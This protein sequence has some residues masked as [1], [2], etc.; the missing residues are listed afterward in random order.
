MGPFIVEEVNETRLE[1]T[2]QS[3][4]DR[5]RCIRHMTHLKK[6]EQLDYNNFVPANLEENNLTSDDINYND[7]DDDVNFI[8]ARNEDG[9]IS[10][11]PV[12]TADEV[13]TEPLYHDSEFIE[14]TPSIGIGQDKQNDQNSNTNLLLG[15]RLG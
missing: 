12:R 4:K 5:K 11:D 1:C 3:V 2:L 15:N 9:D 8:N 14:Q 10:P 13:E 6:Q 7:D